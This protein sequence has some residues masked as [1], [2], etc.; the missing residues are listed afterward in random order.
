MNDKEYVENLLLNMSGGLLPKDLQPDE[1]RKLERVIG[2]NW[3]EKLG[4]TNDKYERP[5]IKLI[6]CGHGLIGCE[7]C[8]DIVDN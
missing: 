1:V 5:K 7:I 3:F 8:G 2:S 6:P 4:Y